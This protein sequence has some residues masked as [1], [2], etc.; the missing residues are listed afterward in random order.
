MNEIECSKLVAVLFAAYPVQSSRLSAEQA[1]QTS[2]A[3]RRMLSDLDFVTVSAAV[4]R[5]I[6]TREYFPTVAEIRAS[7]VTVERGDT[8]PG[9]AAWGEVIRAVG[10]YG[11]YRQPG[12][13]FHFD[14][15]ITH[16]CVSSFGW[17]NICNS[18]NQ[19]S[20]RARFVDLYDQLAKQ[21]RTDQVAGNL[22]AAARYRE[23]R[24]SENGS[25]SIG[26]VVGQL[27]KKGFIQ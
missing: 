16:R 26:D 15:P 27:A 5:L 10:R 2:A 4:E 25:Q 24:S 11:I 13:D 18:E 3:Y 19:V 7:C 14:D 9:G 20:D 12:V 23:L 1:R 17:Q 6:S 8:K 22:P 21:D